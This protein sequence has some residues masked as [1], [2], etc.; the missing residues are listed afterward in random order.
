M[1]KI[2]PAPPPANRIPVEIPVPPMKY[3]SNTNNN[4]TDI[5]PDHLKSKKYCCVVLPQCVIF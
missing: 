4:I 1:Y 5:Q 2:A 3:D